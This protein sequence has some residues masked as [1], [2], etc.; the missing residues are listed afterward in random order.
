MMTKSELQRDQSRDAG[1]LA[2]MSATGFMQ[3]AKRMFKEECLQS[4][5]CHFEYLNVRI[6][7][8]WTEI[9]RSAPT[10][11]RFLQ[12]ALEVWNDNTSSHEARRQGQQ[13][14]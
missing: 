8:Y 14:L 11:P 7:C 5:D 10:S 1:L 4:L 3:S 12:L 13:Q 9:R 2:E 6:Q